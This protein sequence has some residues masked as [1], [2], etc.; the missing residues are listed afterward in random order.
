MYSDKQ[1]IVWVI[2]EHS[3]NQVKAITY[4]VIAFATKV[5]AAIGA[6]VKVLVLGQSVEIQAK[7]I[8]AATGCKVVGISCPSALVYNA[9]VYRALLKKF[10]ET[11]APRLILVPHTATGW[12][13]APGLAVD[14]SASN[15][16]A[17]FGF[18]DERGPVFTRRICNGKIYEDVRPLEGATAIV[19]VIPGAE[20]PAERRPS[21]SGSVEIIEMD[22]PPVRA[23]TMR[24]VEAPPRSLN[25]QQAEVIVAVG[26]GIG[27]PEH[28]EIVRELAR[29]FERGA[30]GASRPVC[31][32]GWL[33]FGHQ[34]GMTGQTVSPKLYIACG[35][36]GAMQHTMGMNKS[37]M[38]V[39]IN[40]DKNAMFFSVAHFCIL[41]DLHKFI[42]VLIE[43]IREFA[44]AGV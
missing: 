36:S 44:R 43:K 32:I 7:E 31:D 17:V 22:S 16:T 33:P 2:A 40:R 20:A 23:K 15:I 10:F 28:I 6:E 21:A 29:L 8:S 11:S 3:Q 18:K 27:A 35:I 42:P 9:E 39:A 12:D 26:R 24:Y 41:A 14:L 1:N 38:I 37:D 30:V 25:L 5:A 4:E 19:T 13:F 34:V